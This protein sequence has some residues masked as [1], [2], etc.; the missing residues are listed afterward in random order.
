MLILKILLFKILFVEVT[1]LCYIIYLYLS[2]IIKI[3]MNI[4]YSHFLYFTMLFFLLSFSSLF[5]QFPNNG[6]FY[7]TFFVYLVQIFT[8]CLIKHVEI[9]QYFHFIRFIS[10]SMLPFKS[11][12][13]AA[14]GNIDSICGGPHPAGAQNL[15]MTLLFRSTTVIAWDTIWDSRDWAWLL[16]V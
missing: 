1:S 14:N 15:S 6:R 4:Y 11:I 13:D 2:Y 9:I 3:S 10:L 16:Y 5:F 8:F 7:D 12:H